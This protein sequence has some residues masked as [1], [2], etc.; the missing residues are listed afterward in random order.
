MT[1]SHEFFLRRIYVKPQVDELTNVVAKIDWCML[2]TRN[3]AKSIAAGETTLN[4]TTLNAGN[5]TSI[6]TLTAD[7]VINWVIQA[8]GGE[9]FIDR[10]KEIYEPEIAR[11]ERE[12]DLVA[13]DIPLINPKRWDDKY[14]R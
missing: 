7:A 13:W 14:G 2:L 6:T 8:E 11:K 9:A 5:F 1:I 10:I 4:L 12:L 3:G